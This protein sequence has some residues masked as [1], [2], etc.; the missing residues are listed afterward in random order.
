MYRVFACGL[1]E[2]HNGP[3]EE[4]A[5]IP[6]MQPLQLEVVSVYGVITRMNSGNSNIHQYNYRT[7]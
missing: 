7:H 5:L 4:L 2:G 1:L 6:D 3:H